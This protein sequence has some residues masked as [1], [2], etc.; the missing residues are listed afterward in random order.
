MPSFSDLRLD[1]PR[2]HLRPLQPDDAPALF[3]I[4]ADPAFMR[5]WSST[6]WTSLGQAQA[7]IEGDLRDLAAGA[8]LRL[9]IVRRA[10]GRLI[11]TASLFNL[12]AQN[13]RA[14]VGYGI[15]S[16]CWRQG[17]VSEAL[18]A[19]LDHAFGPMGLRRLEADI[20]PRNIAS[21]RSLEKLGFQREGLL[22]E[23]W[24]VGGEVSD[25]ALYG[26]L[27]PQRRRPAPPRPPAP[28]EAG[29]TVRALGLEDVAA[30]RDLMLLAYRLAPEAF[31]STAEERAALPTSWW[32]QRVSAGDGRSQA[33]GAFLGRRLVG[34]VAMEYGERLRTRH[35]AHLVGMFV[36]AAARRRG[37]GLALVQAALAHARDSRGAR[38]VQLTVTEGNTEALRLYRAAG[39]TEWGVQPLAVATDSGLRGKVHMACVFPAG[40]VA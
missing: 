35:Q 2:L 4:H 12:S 23:R 37:A 21:A 16:D 18:D 31:T 6:P 36:D 29:V 14:E 40:A 8:H 13:R 26:L 5:Y 38:L 17:Y 25:S 15:A 9:G 27:A 33:F 28:P 22:R 7:L 1:T 20:D 3:A 30:Y 11:G 10:D 32:A 19:L 34:A 24:I 39:F